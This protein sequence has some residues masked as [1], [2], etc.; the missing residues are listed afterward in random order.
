M[1]Y[2]LNCTEL[3]SCFDWHNTTPKISEDEDIPI[4]IPGEIRSSDEDHWD[5]F[6]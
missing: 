4:D 6:I 3:C 1:T 5:K 2:N